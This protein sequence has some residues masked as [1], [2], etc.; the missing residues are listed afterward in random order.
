MKN[1]K[2]EFLK[3]AL[4]DLEEII[5]YIAQDSI[6]A[7]FKIHD[8]I[9]LKVK[10]LEEFPNLGPYVPDEKMRESGFRMLM[11]RPYIAFYKEINGVIYIYR[12]M[13][14]ARDYSSLYNMISTK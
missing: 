10:K 12:V 3:Q 11:I 9:I 7:A 4:N 6:D 2:V 8:E 13:H 1:H 14:G 5:L